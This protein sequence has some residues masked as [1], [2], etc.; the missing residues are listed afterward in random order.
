M[1]IVLGEVI[2]KVK[3]I[4]TNAAGECSGQFLRLRISVDVTK[5]L[6]KTI[7]LEQY[8]EDDGDITMRMMYGQMPDFCFCCG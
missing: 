6:K 8:K 1:A 4:K 3:E 5:L 7:E 2:G